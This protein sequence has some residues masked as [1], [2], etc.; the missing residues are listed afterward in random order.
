MKFAAPVAGLLLVLCPWL[1]VASQEPAPANAAA[2]NV[3]IIRLSRHH[4]AGRRGELGGGGH[5][6]QLQQ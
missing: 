4:S 2:Y 3:E 5:R 6:A 1:P